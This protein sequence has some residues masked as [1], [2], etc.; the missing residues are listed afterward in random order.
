MN[1]V[2]PH[3]PVVDLFRLRFIPK[4]CGSSELLEDR[5]C[6]L[7]LSRRPR[8]DVADPVG[9]RLTIIL[10]EETAAHDTC[11]TVYIEP[12]PLDEYRFILMLTRCI[13]ARD[14]VKQRTVSYDRAAGE[15]PRAK[16][17]ARRFSSFDVLRL[18]MAV[19]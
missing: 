6:E 8:R 4:V 9:K 7:V 17:D 10:S 1:S 12:P 2:I 18:R 19:L 15:I 16:R 5:Y 11:Y 3:P 14:A 13:R